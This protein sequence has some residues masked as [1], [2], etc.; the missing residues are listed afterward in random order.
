MAS[1]LSVKQIRDILDAAGVDYSNCVE[2][3]DLLR[4]LE[5]VRKS[6][7]PD[8][9][10]SNTGGGA[11]GS[12]GRGSAGG[13]SSSSATSRTSSSSSSSSSATKCT[14]AVEKII[15]DVTKNKDYYDILGVPKGSTDNEIKKAYRKLALKLH[16]D[17][18]SLPGGEDAFKKVGT[19]FHCLSDEDK[20]RQYDQ[21]GH[22]VD[23]NSGGSGGMGPHGGV[24]VDELFRQM[25]AGQQGGRGF[26]GGGFGGPGV[27]M[28]FGG[29][30]PFGPGFM[31]NGGGGMP[32]QQQRGRRGGGG[33][34]AGNPTPPSLMQ[35]LMNMGPMI[36]IMLASTGL[37]GVI[38]NLAFKVRAHSSKCAH[39]ALHFTVASCTSLHCSILHFTSLFILHFTSLFILMS[40]RP[41]NTHF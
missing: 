41:I 28:H 11:G 22:D 17:K 24:D 23:N 19:A 3:K 33:E 18:C 16:P 27:R 8:V 32:G 40:V 5:A 14:D 13:G 34:G 36:F 39:P 21:T 20:K 4:K 37:L 26:Q 12:A 2:K 9:S 38:V 29:G 30:S 25:F 7:K 6:A 15:K 31:F 35:Q 1:G 10:S